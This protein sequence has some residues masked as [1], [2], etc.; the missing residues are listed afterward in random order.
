MICIVQSAQAHKQLRA[1]Q[2]CSFN[3]RTHI[4]VHAGL[5]I[6]IPML[7]AKPSY[8]YRKSAHLLTVRIQG[9]VAALTVGSVLRGTILNDVIFVN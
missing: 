5:R 1:V 6:P 4:V 3:I 8:D 2:M 9:P 7:G